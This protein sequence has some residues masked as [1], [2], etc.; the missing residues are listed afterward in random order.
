MQQR[1]KRKKF[2]E[3]KLFL[4]GVQ[5]F[6]LISS[7]VC[8]T[9]VGVFKSDFFSFGPNDHMFYLGAPINTWSRW[10]ALAVFRSLITL[11]QVGISTIIGPWITT[12]IQADSKYLPE[13]RW[14]CIS[15]VLMFVLGGAINGLFSLFLIFTQADINV[16]EIM[17]E[18]ITVAFWTMPKWINMK[19]YVPVEERKSINDDDQE[20]EM[21]GASEDDANASLVGEKIEKAPMDREIKRI[22]SKLNAI[23]LRLALVEDRITVL[24]KKSN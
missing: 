5:W 9:Y 22:L 6:L 12:S 17:C 2:Y 15:I 8:Y 14:K 7:I 21:D 19:T 11:V 10:S 16:I 24:E 18:I 3:D 4:V 13:P 20:F 1:N 23:S